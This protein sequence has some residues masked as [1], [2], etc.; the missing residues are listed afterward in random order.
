MKKI[1]K[2]LKENKVIRFGLVGVLIS[3]FDILFYTFLF[4]ALKVDS[5][6]ATPISHGIAI[7]LHYFSNKYLVFNRDKKIRA[8]E[9][10]KFIGVNLV[11]EVLSTGL[12]YVFVNYTSI[13]PSI[14]RI[15]VMFIMFALI[16]SLMSKW[17]F[18]KVE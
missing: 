10:A 14:S 16:Y 2:Y 9:V 7:I 18:L 3:I 4:E 11:D 8:F 13:Y 17:V 15:I 1:I 12:M 5:V 6:L